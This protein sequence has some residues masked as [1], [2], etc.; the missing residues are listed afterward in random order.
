RWVVGPGKFVAWSA[1][2][3]AKPGCAITVHPGEE[4]QFLA[5]QAGAVLPL[6][7]DAHRRLRQLGLRTLGRLA[8][9]PEEAI[10]SQFGRASRRWWRRAA[11]AAPGP[12]LGPGPPGPARALLTFFPPVGARE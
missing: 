4:R 7:P 11:G 3:P 10:V 6:D 8:A 5:A 1:R 9:L 2:S 12:G